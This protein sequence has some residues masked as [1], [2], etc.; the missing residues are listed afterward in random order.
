MWLNILL[1]KQ[2]S[3]KSPNIFGFLQSLKIL[4]EQWLIHARHLKWTV[5]CWCD[6]HSLLSSKVCIRR[7]Q[8]PTKLCVS[9]FLN[10]EKTSA[11]SLKETITCDKMFFLALLG[12][13]AGLI[14]FLTTPKPISISPAAFS[15]FRSWRPLHSLPVV[16]STIPMSFVQQLGRVTS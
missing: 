10:S 8:L 9:D 16:D 12:C 11:C 1:D 2:I 15:L 7:K 6:E 14:G 5:G 13:K 3:T 4:T